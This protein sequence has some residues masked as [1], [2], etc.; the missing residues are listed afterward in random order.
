LKR[1]KIEKEIKQKQTISISYDDTLVPKSVTRQEKHHHCTVPSYFVVFL[2]SNHS[3]LFH[4]FI[5]CCFVWF[6]VGVTLK[7]IQL[8]EETKGYPFFIFFIS[9]VGLSHFFVIIIFSF[10]VPRSLF[11]SLFLFLA[12]ILVIFFFIILPYLCFFLI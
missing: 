5:V 11:V 1:K 9:M 8:K 7:K 2:F 3:C 10:W 4:T 12:A 6:G